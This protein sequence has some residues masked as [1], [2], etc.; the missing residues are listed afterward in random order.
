LAREQDREPVA[1]LSGH[2]LLHYRVEKK[3]GEGGMGVVYRAEDTKL[4]RTVALKFLADDLS[5]DPQA[6]ARFQREARA[7]SA[8]NHSNICTIHDIDEVDGRHFIAMEFLDGKSLREH[9]QGKPLSTGEILDFAI[10]IAD[11]L[12]AAHAEG[13]IHRDIKPANIFVTKR[14][15][16]KILDFGSAKLAPRRHSE[17]TAAPTTGAEDSLTGTGMAVG[18]VAYMSPEQA[19][20]KDLD[21]RTDLFS[22]GVVLYEMATG[23]L[24]FRG[25]SSTATIDEILHKAPTAPVRINPD[26]PADLE[27]IINKALEKDREVRYQ[28]VKDLLADLKRLK[29][30]SESDRGASQPA[31]DAAQ[32]RYRRLRWILPLAAVFVLIAIFGSWYLTPRAPAL[33][34]RDVIV[35]SEF[36]N[37]TGD[38]V[39]DGTL[40]Q[41][42]SIQLEQSPFL[43]VF[44]E[45]SVR[46]TLHYMGRSANDRMTAQVAR[47]IGQRE[48]LKAVVEG[49]IAALGG[50]YLMVVDATD[51]QSGA[52]LIS[53]KEEVGGK[54]QVIAGLDRLASRL[55]RRLGESRVSV[56]R[57]QAPLEQATTSSLEAL[58]AYD[59]GWKE[60]IV[61]KQRQSIPYFMRAVELDPNFAEAYAHLANIHGN[62]H[63]PGPAAEYAQKAYALR[64][65][66]TEFERYHIISTYH[67][68]VTG[69]LLK[70]IETTEL[71]RRFYPR[72][73]AAIVTFAWDSAHLG[74]FEDAAAASRQGLAL[75]PNSY[76]PY[77]GLANYCIFLDR[78]EE[79]KSVC[80]EEA[81]KFPE[82][83]NPHLDLYLIALLQGDTAG[84]QR[85]LEWAK[86]KADEATFLD[87]QRQQAVQS[88]QFN[89][90]AKLARQTAVLAGRKAPTGSTI[91]AEIQAYV[92]NYD[93]ARKDAVATLAGAN[94][95]RSTIGTAALAFALARDATQA[96]K[97]AADLDSRFPDDTLLHARTIPN[98]RAAIELTRNNPQKAIDLLNAAT[99]Y[100][101]REIISPYLRGM[102]YLREG[103]AAE[104]AAEFQKI[105]DR[106]AISQFSI[107]HP[108][109]YLG[110]ARAAALSGDTA[111]S[112]EMYQKFFDLWKDADPDIP[113]LKQAKTEN[114]KLK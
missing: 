78:L 73:M 45:E 92:G 41:A 102:A 13:I 21:A 61:G 17:G 32:S 1:D 89:L 30:D 104:A 29:R 51:C 58:K 8:L 10:Q 20:G 83:P 35:L 19:L 114:E 84:A 87:Y 38:S 60:Q 75:N 27:R 7:V 14:G 77:N 28:T 2:A 24:P 91:G 23:V 93:A 68:W 112:R 110:L 48:G 63:E 5:R 94:E 70:D 34:D 36:V 88:G 62:L 54:E 50:H 6:L 57:F 55:R 106:R 67:S 16:A 59:L 72:S 56:Q 111:K 49:S 95:N 101:R 66:V 86:G 109:A 64:D 42:L 18:T 15:Q 98:I 85:Q 43:S 96:E 46:E 105:I 82:A 37:N 44:P 25:E 90:N 100:E 113:I 12:D 108:L 11:G 74:R 33:T 103:A 53:D 39:F 107:L 26:L 97:L 47:E 76:Y 4:K 9:I 79:A 52:T 22:F 65:R 40:K 31:P 69:D 81:Q 71:W 80:G 99:P 3:I